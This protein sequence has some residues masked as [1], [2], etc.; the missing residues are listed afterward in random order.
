MKAR[1]SILRFG[2]GKACGSLSGTRQILGRLAGVGHLLV[3]VGDL[4]QDRFGKGAAEERDAGGQ[5]LN[6]S[7][8][9]GD[10]R[11]AGDGPL[12]W[13]FQNISNRRQRDRLAR[14]G[15][16]LRYSRFYFFASPVTGFSI[17][18]LRTITTL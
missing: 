11:I 12:D 3:G 10:V 2:R 6:I 9:N 4:D 8:R 15:R 13:S 5:A 16:P 14:L 7:G 1:W 18:K 17:S